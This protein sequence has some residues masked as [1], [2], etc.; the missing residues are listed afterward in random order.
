MASFTAFLE[1]G[2]KQYPLQRYELGMR[3]EIDQLG[4]PASPVLGVA[5]TCTLH[6]PV[7]SDSFLYQ[8]MLSPTMQQDGKI[9]LLQAGAK[10]TEKTISFFNAYCIDMNLN[11]FPGL[12]GGMGSSWLQ[13]QISPQRVA[14]GAIVHD[15][16][17]PLDS[18]GAGE[19]FSLAAY[20][21]NSVTAKAP[22]PP[23]P[24]ICAQVAD[25]TDM[26]KSK[27]ERYNARLAV[28]NEARTHMAQQLP[29]SNAM[30]APADATRVAKNLP[31]VAEQASLEKLTNRLE[32]NNRAIERARLV[33]DIYVW[34]KE[35]L[36]KSQLADPDPQK[37]AAAARNL[38]DIRKKLK[39]PGVHPPEGWVVKEPFYKDPA[40]GFAYAVYEST[41]EKPAR[42][43]LVFRGTDNADNAVAD[44]KTN[45]LQGMGME[46]R[47][48]SQSIDKALELK[49]KYGSRIEIAG[50]SKAGGQAAAASIVTGLKGFTF[51]AAGVHEKTVQ[52]YEKSRDDAKKLIAG[53]PLVNAF[54][55]PYDILSNVQDV[56]QLKKAATISGALP[57]VG[58]GGG[59]Y[60]GA[61]AGGRAGAAV[62]PYVNPL[63]PTFLNKLTGQVG[64]GVAGSVVGGTL[65][66]LLA[67]IV[68]AKVY[69]NNE[70]PPAAGVR[71]TL[72]AQ[73]INGN[74]IDSPGLRSTLDRVEYHGMPYL[75]DS[76]EKQKKD[77]LKGI[78]KQL[79]C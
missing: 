51:N 46:T 39:M 34:G 49:D 78:A 9:R 45:A 29:G 44:W 69:F 27:K 64:G 42:P 14:V 65:A 3:Q 57:L 17:W 52:R 62:G 25:A 33:D 74:K 41:F 58:F 31:A 70:M 48:Y 47:Q 19:I 22:K 8:W 7:S 59:G 40:T 20:Q 24:A 4:R 56:P 38:A 68:G 30:I 79:G 26:R 11:F 35:D 54:N 63:M 12:S 13:L 53:K 43:V 37:A 16:N 28:I 67:P 66:A 77:D 61:M 21:A 18:H 36:Y 73:D 72:P 71:T 1:V 76:M 75:I 60:G 5:I 50:H 6:S 15:N 23:K 32:L 55:F 10:A 2:G